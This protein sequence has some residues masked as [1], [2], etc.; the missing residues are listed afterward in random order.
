MQLFMFRPEGPL[1][2][3]KP[4]EGWTVRPYREGDGAEWCRCCAGGCLGVEEE[5][6]EELFE[7][8]MLHSPFVKKENVLF[9][10]DGTGHVGG[11]TTYRET[12]EP[13]HGV[14]HMVAVKTEDRGKGLSAPI[15][16]AAMEVAVRNGCKYLQLTTDDFRIPAI[17]TYLKLGFVPQLMKPGLRLRWE[18]LLPVLGL[19][20]LPCVDE[21][22]M[23]APE[24]MTTNAV[25]TA[26]NLG[27]GI[28]RISMPGH[29]YTYLIQGT[30]NAV[31]I[32]TGYGIKGFRSYVETLTD[33]PVTVILTHMHLDHAWGAAEFGKV[34][35]DPSDIALCSRGLAPERK[36]MLADRLGCPDAE[37][38]D[39]IG[40][41]DCLPL[42]DGQTFDLGGVTVETGRMPGHTPGS[43]TVLIREARTVLLGDACNSMAYL[44]IPNTLT[45]RE[46]RDGLIT[47]QKKNAGRYE[48][49]LYSHP[50]NFGGPEIVEEMIG[51]TDLVVNNADAA[52]P[53]FG[54][55]VLI[56]AEVNPETGKRIDG[57]AANLLYRQEN[58]I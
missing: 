12:E 6:T 25:Y 40:A 52:L 19:D 3:V 33:K 42:E 57:K 36:K 56:A 45:I 54:E 47:W 35:I 29:V 46:Y 55:G 51:L 17:R 11:T 15:V 39:P 2:A 53:G 13:D 18:A 9:I 10:V 43:I 41:E 23:P 20:S 50:H 1:P 34:W 7:R 27:G 16:A 22:G 58:R 24:I 48:T 44:Q 49:V 8:L 28:T 38:V 14:M 4:P 31:L 21:N 26:E 5:P 30:E 37:F 32:D